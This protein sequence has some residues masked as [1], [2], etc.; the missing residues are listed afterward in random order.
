MPKIAVAQT[1]ANDSIPANLAIATEMIAE[2][3]EKGATAIFLP[4]CF[5]LM[6][7]S[8]RQL[9]ES[10]EKP[11]TGRIQETMAKAARQ[12]EMLVFSGT[13]PIRSE[14]PNR[15][16]NSSLVYDHNGRELARYDKIHLF[17]VQLAN[18]EQYLESGYTM[19][20]QR[21]KT[22]DCD[23]GRVGLSVCYDLRF[24]ELYRRLVAQNA[25]IFAVPS[26]FS[27]TT[28]PAHWHTLLRARAIENFCYVI[29]SAQEGT[30]PSGR[31][32]YG[33]SLVVDPWGKIIAEKQSGAGLLMVDIDLNKV[34]Q[35]R[36][37]VPS[38]EHRNPGI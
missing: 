2:A 22:I 16:Y 10:A 33:H 32:T 7:S 34:E 1:C 28:G 20:G 35:V 15:V 17:D 4:E 19:P 6:Q 12:Y 8:R 23:L 13:I 5:A 9:R 3:A 29:A 26:A 25:Q 21:V 38:L 24:P 18:G 37:E 31:V 27:S 36:K 11:G 14:D 30:H